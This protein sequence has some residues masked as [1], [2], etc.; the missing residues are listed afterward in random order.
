LSNGDINQWLTSEWRN[1]TVDPVVLTVSLRNKRNRF[2]LVRCENQPCGIVALADW[3]PVDQVAMV[4][5]V[6]GE[7]NLGGRGVITQALQLLVHTAFWELDIA[8]LHA[9]II[10]DNLRSRRVLEKCGFREIGRLREAVSKDGRRMDRIYFDITKRD[11][12]L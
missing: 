9:W 11:L 6:L 7:S 2:Y 8:A 5:Y 10:E 12:G 4:W 1:R 3:D